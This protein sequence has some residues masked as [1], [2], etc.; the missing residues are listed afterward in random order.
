MTPKKTKKKKKKYK[1]PF[2]GGL[3]SSIMKL[4]WLKHVFIQMVAKIN[5]ALRRSVLLNTLVGWLVV[6]GLTAL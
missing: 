1:N 2:Y 6:W 3:E 4:Q 5:I